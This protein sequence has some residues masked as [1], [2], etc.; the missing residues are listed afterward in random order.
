MFDM[1]DITIKN[2]TYLLEIEAKINYGSDLPTRFI[3][4]EVT[5]DVKIQ[6]EV[7]D[8]E[9]RKF[10]DT[11][12]DQIAFGNQTMLNYLM[13]LGSVHQRSPF[14]GIIETFPNCGKNYQIL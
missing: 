7:G 14:D 1:G 3:G 12:N 10:I 6:I 4:K 13:N 5:A 2:M 8:C 11:S 9:P